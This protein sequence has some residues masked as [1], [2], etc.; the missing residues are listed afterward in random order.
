MLSFGHAR[1]KL[2][3]LADFEF[4]DILCRDDN[5]LAGL[6]VLAITFC[7]VLF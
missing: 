1:V 2:E 5:L 3:S 7:S 4:H 6:R